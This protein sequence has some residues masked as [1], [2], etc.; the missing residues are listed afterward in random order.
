MGTSINLVDL[1]FF[2]SVTTKAIYRDFLINAAFANVMFQEIPKMQY[3]YN[4]T[5]TAMFNPMR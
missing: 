1:N 4:V 5:R 2:A 3:F